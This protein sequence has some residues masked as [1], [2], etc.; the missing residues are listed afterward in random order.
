MSVCTLNTLNTELDPSENEDYLLYILFGL[1]IITCILRAI[2]LLT[3]F[4]FETPKF[5][6]LK[7]SKIKALCILGQIYK[8]EY[9]DYKYK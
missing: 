1:P 3:V 8:E 4:S 9:V 5:H 2:L 7:G 6:I